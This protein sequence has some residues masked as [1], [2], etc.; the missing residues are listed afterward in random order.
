MTFGMEKKKRKLT[1]NY[2]YYSIIKL[3]YLAN[4]LLRNL[5]FIKPIF[6]KKLILINKQFLNLIVIFIDC[7]ICLNNKTKTN[8]QKFSLSL[9]FF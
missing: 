9:S 5:N 1:T 8:K 3:V 7:I 6:I 2:R 4:G